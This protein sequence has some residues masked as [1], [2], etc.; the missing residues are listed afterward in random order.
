MTLQVGNKTIETSKEVEQLPKEFVDFAITHRSTNGNYF[1]NQRDMHEVPYKLED[2]RIV[3]RMWDWT[4]KN[5]ALSIRF[6]FSKPRRSQVYGNHLTNS[7]KDA[8][9]YAYGWLDYDEYFVNIAEGQNIYESLVK[10]N[11]DNSFPAK[12]NDLIEYWK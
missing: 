5:R 7:E 4:N 3:N 2:I 11:L 8:F 12:L 9:C 1:W 6:T 10:F